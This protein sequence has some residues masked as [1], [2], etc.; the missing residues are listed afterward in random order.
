MAESDLQTV[1]V[2]ENN[3]D[4]ETKNPQD[5]QRESQIIEKKKFKFGD[6]IRSIKDKIRNTIDERKER[7]N[8]QN[9]QEM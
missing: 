9:K 4:E 5:V 3:S 7:K 2:N 6:G 1:V 8:L